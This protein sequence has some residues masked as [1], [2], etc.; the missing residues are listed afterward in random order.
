MTIPSRVSLIM[1]CSGLA[2]VV[3]IGST[4]VGALFAREKGQR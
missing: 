1:G 4:I 2:N 3:L